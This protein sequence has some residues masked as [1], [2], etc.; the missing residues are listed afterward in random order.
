MPDPVAV[1]A[2]KRALRARIRE[3]RDAADSGLRAAWSADITTH[4]LE[5]VDAARP[6]V[7]LSYVA[8]GTEFDTTAFN[9]ALLARGIDLI[10]PRMDRP[11]KRLALFRVSDPALDLVAGVWGILEPD[12]ARCALVDP[13]DVDWA[14]IPGL[15]FDASGGR[16]GYGAGFY[17]RLLPDLPPATPRVAAAFGCQIIDEIPREAHDLAVDRVVTDAGIVQPRRS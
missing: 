17:D 2:L 12:P 11:T 5:F 10:L 7:A 8:F 16:L 6:R 3:A 14:L 9:A 4:L 1:P 15:A 13:L